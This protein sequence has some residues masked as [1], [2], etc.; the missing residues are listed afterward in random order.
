MKAFKHPATILALL[1]LFVALGGRAALAKQ[2]I[3]G[4]QIKN[5]SIPTKKLTKSA[6]K[7]LRGRRGRGGPAGPKGPAGPAGNAGAAGPVGPAGPPGAPGS[8]GSPGVVSVGA[9]AGPIGSIGAFQGWVAAGPVTTLTTTATQSIVAS[10]SAAL[11]TSGATV[12]PA[13]IAICVSPAGAGKESP[14]HG[15]V[16]VTVTSTRS[17][18][19]ASATGAPG[20]G[21]WDVGMCVATFNTINS[22][23]R[24]VGYAFVANGTPVSET[25]TNESSHR[26]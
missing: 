5:H 16:F 22:N 20:A 14:L 26:R 15:T 10:G 23:D 2:F 25:L 17:S 18:Y 6:I 3:S 7:S 19:A 21:T 1:A 8:P 12:A 13:D 9:F 4:L 24:S 11:A